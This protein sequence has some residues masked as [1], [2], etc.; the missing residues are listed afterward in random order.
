[1]AKETPED[2]RLKALAAARKKLHVDK[3]EEIRKEGESKKQAIENIQR[4]LDL[5][6]DLTKALQ[7]Q[8][9]ISEK[10]NVSKEKIFG[11]VNQ[12]QGAVL[13]QTDLNQALVEV[14][15]IR[16]DISKNSLDL[17]ESEKTILQTQ[18]QAAEEILSTRKKEN[19]ALE[20]VKE[21]QKEITDSAQS[22]LKSL[23][24]GYET[25]LSSIPGGGLLGAMLGGGLAAA[26]LGLAIAAIM[27]FSEENKKIREDLG[28]SAT[29]AAKMNK[30]ARELALNMENIA[31]NVDDVREAQAS[32]AN[33]FMTTARAS[34]KMLT[35]M[36]ALNKTFGV[37]ADTSA[38]VAKTFQEMGESVE[39]SMDLQ[40][41][42]ANLAKAAKVAPGEVM[43]DIA[44]SAALAHKYF[45]GNVKELAKQAIE[46]RR[47]GLSLSDIEGA[48]S[49]TLDIES[50][51]AAEMEAQVMLGKEINFDKARQLL[52]QGN[53]AGAMDSMLGQLG[54]IQEFNK[55][56]LLQKEAAAAAIG[57]T[58]DQLGTALTKQADMA[59][60]SKADREEIEAARLALEG[61]SDLNAEDIKQRELQAIQQEKMAASM[62]KMILGL[63][64]MFIPLMENVLTVVGPIV[65][66]FGSVIGFL[67]EIPG[68]G[69]II[70][71]VLTGLAIKSLITAV[72]GIWTTFSQI[73]FGL[74]VPMAIAA[75]GGLMAGIA[76]M[77]SKVGSYAVGGEVEDTGIAEVHAGETIV[78]KEISDAVKSSGVGAGSDLGSK[79]DKLIAAVNQPVQVKLG[80]KFVNE[81]QSAQSLKRNMTMGLDNTYGA[82]V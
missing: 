3:M 47:L 82:T 19:L 17:N 11:T 13:S 15:K 7:H 28:V 57:L 49:G 5:E 38:Q 67:S 68:L 27:A 76:S 34:D 21:K 65:S 46:A 8:F 72:T 62:D 75:T 22:E 18:L 50:S 80:N 64:E 2:K 20:A 44:D 30:H 79:L 45:K 54:G 81:V 32:I 74:G 56:D 42:T 25:T 77:T 10:N 61:K 71:G 16:Y 1:M 26:G 6:N 33:T 24:T 60:L 36:V 37:T 70:L 66:A 12:I 51:L 23:T 58:V 43:K 41:F 4:Q 73:P 78:T 40:Y 53:M 52:L 48:V 14:D 69:G 35:D 55:M 39:T 31:G 59:K 9:D 63:Q 29:H